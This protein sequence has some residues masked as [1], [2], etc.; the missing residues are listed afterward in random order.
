MNYSE[1]ICDFEDDSCQ[2]FEALEY[3]GNSSNE[4][5]SFRT[6]GDF[7][8]LRSDTD[9]GICFSGFFF[10]RFFPDCETEIILR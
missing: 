4:H 8:A 3:A 1:I 6:K 7:Q 9:I 5:C 10:P 2:E